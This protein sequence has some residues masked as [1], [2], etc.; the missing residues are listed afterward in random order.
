MDMRIGQGYDIHRLEPG[1]PLM[2]GGLDIP[3]DAGCAGHSDGDALLHAV[4]DALLGAVAAGDIGELFPDTDRGNYDRPSRDFLQAAARRVRDA[5][6]VVANID[7]TVTTERPRLSAH[8]IDMAREIARICRIEPGRVS[9]KAKTNEGLDAVGT[10]D[11]LVATA[12]ALVTRN[13][14]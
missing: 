1:R 8:K 2:L 11:A 10:G 3:S 9:V 6:Y 7:A 14:A 5:G 13:R 4:T 12:A